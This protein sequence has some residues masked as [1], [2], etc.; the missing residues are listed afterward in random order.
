[1]DMLMIEAKKHQTERMK[2]SKNI[3][4]IRYE[5][6]IVTPNIHMRLTCEKKDGAI[7]AKAYKTIPK[8]FNVVG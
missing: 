1:M 6:N 2:Y 8:Y 7:V 5:I 3:A 4:E